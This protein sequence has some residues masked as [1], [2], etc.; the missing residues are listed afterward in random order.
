M[1]IP[2]QLKTHLQNMKN[3]RDEA[4]FRATELSYEQKAQVAVANAIEREIFSFEDA[5]D[6]SFKKEQK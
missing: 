1:K 5:M 6:S 2:G 4:K 3:R